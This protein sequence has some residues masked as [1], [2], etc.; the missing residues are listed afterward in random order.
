MDKWLI[1][2]HLI[3]MQTKRNIFSIITQPKN[4]FG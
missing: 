1:V 4:G 3:I 2:G